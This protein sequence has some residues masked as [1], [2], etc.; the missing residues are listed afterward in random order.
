MSLSLLGPKYNTSIYFYD[1]PFL[2][3]MIVSRKLRDLNVGTPQRNWV[4]SSREVAV[5]V[6]ILPVI[7]GQSVDSVE[8][9]SGGAEGEGGWNVFWASCLGLPTAYCVTTVLPG[10]IEVPLYPPVIG[11]LSSTLSSDW[12]V[13]FDN[14]TAHA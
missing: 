3:L 10:L 4:N 7:V 1:F 11:H 12:L 13:L 8:A 9:W 6:S 5:W 2:P 14:R